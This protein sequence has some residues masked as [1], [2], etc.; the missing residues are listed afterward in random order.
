M[1]ES[2]QPQLPPRPETYMDRTT[3][4]IKPGEDAPAVRYILALEAENESLR[5]RFDEAERD[6]EILED[7]LNEISK[8]EFAN[9]GY[10][11]PQM[12]RIMS[13]ELPMQ[14]QRAN[15]SEAKCDRTLEVIREYRF[16][17][18]GHRLCSTDFGYCPTCIKADALLAEKRI[19]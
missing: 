4:R 3:E 6:R 17:S 14:R 11:L 7:A 13:I 5:A 15:K 1:S 9:S 2:A 18:I 8:K 12:V 16:S 10:N 19:D